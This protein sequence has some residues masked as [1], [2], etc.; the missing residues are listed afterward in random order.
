[1]E[2]GIRQVQDEII[3]RM[4][5]VGI[6]SLNGDSQKISGLLHA[7]GMIAQNSIRSKMDLGPFTPLKPSTLAARRRRGI[8]GIKPLIATGELKEAVGYTVEE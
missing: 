8:E 7:I 3:N 5:Q 4:H 6:A 2:P 1:M